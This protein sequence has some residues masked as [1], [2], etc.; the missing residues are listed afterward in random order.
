MQVGARGDTSLESV[1]V[2]CTC[3]PELAS[4]G[5]LL[6]CTGACTTPH[7]HGR[8]KS[9][10]AI[11]AT[12]L[13][14][15]TLFRLFAFQMNAG[16]WSRW[17]KEYSIEY[18]YNLPYNL[19]IH[20][21]ADIQFPLSLFAPSND[22]YKPHE[23]LVHHSSLALTPLS[24]SRTICTTKTISL[25]DSIPSPEVFELLYCNS[26][27]SAIEKRGF[28]GC[29]RRCCSKSPSG[30]DSCLFARSGLTVPLAVLAGGAAAF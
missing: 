20:N 21:H 19:P 13:H 3:Q 25:R 4:K 6:L 28:R 26:T 11:R 16:H 23:L 14:F 12:A 7:E 24:S 17:H 27:S 1:C 22:Q 18:P 2:Q 29:R 15:S 10:I 5:T 9:R 8:G 30:S